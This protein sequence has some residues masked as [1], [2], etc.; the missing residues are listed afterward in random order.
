[1]KI[2]KLLLVLAICFT[3]NLTA[4]SADQIINTYLENSGGKENWKELKATKMVAEVDNQGMKIPIT[5]YNTK[6][7]KQALIVDYMGRKITQMAYDGK[8]LWTTNSNGQAQK[9]DAES[10]ANMESSTNDFPNPFI[11]YE[12]KGYK[13]N[14]LGKEKV[15]KNQTYKIKLVQEPVIVD[16]QQKRNLS[17][18]YFD[19]ET[20]L[21]IKV[22]TQIHGG[23]LDGQFS[24]SEMKNYKKVNGFSFPFSIV[25]N[26]RE[27]KV[28]K[29]EINPNVSNEIFEF[30][31]N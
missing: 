19:V 7:G 11:N 20:G 9:G 31:E 6:E 18:Y 27:L 30:P 15:G 21:P 24:I 17:Y 3:S 26:G 12:E 4:Q 29:V 8:T 10:T 25:E 28:K 2:L 23:T 22:E 13:V 16:G 14:F 1:M 5:I